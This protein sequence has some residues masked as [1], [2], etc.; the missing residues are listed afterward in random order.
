MNRSYD[1]IVV[2][3]GSAGCVM[4]ARLSENP[5]REVALIEAG[6]D[7]PTRSTLPPEI[8][9]GTRLPTNSSQAHDSGIASVPIRPGAPSFP[10]PR[11][12]I[13]GGVVGS[14]RLVCHA[15]FPGGLR[16]LGSGRQ[17]GL[18]IQRSSRHVPL[19]EWRCYA[20]NESAPPRRVVAVD[21]QHA[22]NG[23]AYGA[24]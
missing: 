3:A 20:A 23:D 24:G 9:D 15:R 8:A 14:Q 22:G 1:V 4:A 2:G 7:Y 16:Q 18:G 17:R 5:A 12:R 19:R 10:L 13:V 6:P 11:G 21:L